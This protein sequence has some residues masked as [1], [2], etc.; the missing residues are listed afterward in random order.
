MARVFFSYSHADESERNE[1]EKHLSILKREGAIETWH[2]RRI[3]AGS[4]LDSGIDEK[5]T[6]ANLIL[7]LISPDFLA[8]DYCYSREMETALAMRAKGV[9]WVIPIILEYCDWK[10]TPLKDLLAVPKDGKPVSEY[11]NPNKAYNEITEEIRR[12]IEHIAKE[13]S[14]HSTKPQNLATQRSNRGMVTV[15]DNCRSGNLRIKKKFTDLERANFKKDAFEYISKYFHNSLE[16]LKARNPDIDYSFEPEANKFY[17]TLYRAGTEIAAC[18]IINR[19]GN[20]PWGG[21]TYGS[22]RIANSITSALTV[23]D[24]GYTLFLSDSLNPFDNKARLS[25]KGAADRYWDMFI[26]PLQD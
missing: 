9:A 13:S 18:L 23:E 12:V 4:T 11:P 8:S 1:L 3:L 16:E 17:A 26:R 2:D 22:D 15:I 25:K 24:D 10:S 19:I 20:D 14:P 7:L 21:I 6:Q 5:L